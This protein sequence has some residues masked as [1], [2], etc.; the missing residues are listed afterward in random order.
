[1]NEYSWPPTTAPEEASTKRLVE[2][3]A[4]LNTADHLPQL[5]K[6]LVPKDW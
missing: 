6:R 5:Q 4:W 3:D 1:L 2:Q